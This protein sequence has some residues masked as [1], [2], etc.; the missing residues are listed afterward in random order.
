[1][2]KLSLLVCV[3][4]LSWLIT[5]AP[6]ADAMLAT[7]SGSY[8]GLTD[9]TD[10]AITL[11]QFDPDMG[12]LLSATFLLS[13]TMNTNAFA[14]NDGDFYAGW[15]KTI[16]RFTLSGDNGYHGIAISA[17]RDPVRI[18]GAGTPDSSFSLKTMAR[19]TGQPNWTYA[20]PTL[21]NSGSFLEGAATAFVGHG[22]LT[23]LLST[24]NADALSIAGA[25][26]SGQPQSRFGVSTHVDASVVVAYDYVPAPIPGALW[27]L[28]SGLLG[29]WGWRRQVAG[30]LGC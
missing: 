22:D 30:A 26:T 9:V 19:V 28:G 20:G 12:R 1:M 27:L 3:A 8:S 15:D 23:F 24:L 11:S 2:K 17:A 6:D 14:A 18:V 13:A 16:Y 25:Q 29:L 21:S 10:R 7:Y 5:T 4:I